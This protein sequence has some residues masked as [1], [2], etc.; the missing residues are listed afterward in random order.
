[1]IEALKFDTIKVE[2]VS[3]SISAIDAPASVWLIDDAPTILTTFTIARELCSYWG[4]GQVFH[5][6]ITSRLAPC[7]K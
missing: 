7:C 6:N 3:N 5:N 1:M 4:C 2:L